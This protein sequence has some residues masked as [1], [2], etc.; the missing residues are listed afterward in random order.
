MNKMTKII[1]AAVAGVVLVGAVGAAIVWTVPSVQDRLMARVIEAR[2]ASNDTQALLND[3]GLHVLLCGTG[4]PMPDP[5][6]ANACS[7]VIAGGH[8]VIIDTGPGSWKKFAQ[9]R[10]PAS[11]I[12]AVL[13]THLHSDH[14]GD[15]G[16]FGVQTWIGG[17][18]KPLSVTGPTALPEPAE[19]AD[20]NGHKFGTKGTEDVVAGLTLAYDADAAYR[21]LHHGADYLLPDGAMLQGHNIVTPQKNE[22]VTVYD[23]DGLKISA[24]LVDHMPV[25]PAYGFRAEYKGRVAVFSGDTAKVESIELF[26]KDADLLVHEALNNEMV[27]LITN[28]L[29]KTGGERLGKMAH[30]TLDYHVSPVDAAIMAKNANVKLLVFSHIVPP[31][32]TALSEHM[33]MRGVADVRGAGDTKLGHDGMLISMPADS[34]KIVVSDLK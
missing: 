19:A 25:Q 23:K 27:Q 2:V 24:F 13:L 9:S 17:R 8:I 6:R 34:D 15:L 30:D 20:S 11:A 22:L 7:A 29:N 14:M 10:L 31:L 4:S 3:G 5:A 12:D 21:I 32:P 26:S 1:G 33:F 28:T 16:E 18:T